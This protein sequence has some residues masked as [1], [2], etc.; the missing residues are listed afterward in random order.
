MVETTE[1]NRPKIN[2]QRNPSILIPDTNL[3]ASKIISTLI[4]RRKSPSVIIVS[5]RVKIISNGF[6]IAF[7]IANIK[8]NMMA[9]ANE[10]ITTCGSKSFERMYTATAVISKLII[11]RITYFL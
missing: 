7:R 10:V 9:V 6:T 1:S 11:N 2:A 3:S 4:T 8:A 5:G